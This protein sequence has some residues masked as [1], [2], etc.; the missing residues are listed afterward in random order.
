MQLFL[1]LLFYLQSSRQGHLSATEAEDKIWK[2]Q[3]WGDHT[4][5]DQDQALPFFWGREGRNYKNILK[6]V[7]SKLIKVSITL[8]NFS[9]IMFVL[10]KVFW[11]QGSLR[12]RQCA[13]PR[14]SWCSFPRI[15]SVDDGPRCW[16]KRLW[17]MGPHN[18]LQ[19]SCVKTRRFFTLCEKAPCKKASILGSVQQYLWAS[20]VK[21]LQKV[22]TLQHQVVQ[23]PSSQ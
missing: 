19:V 22:E 12:C 7:S 10:W 18:T 2:R 9:L 16:T 1:Q 3:N 11:V 21:R 6:E 20:A 23:H 15:P 8:M 5:Q 14:G 13:P 4:W 17:R